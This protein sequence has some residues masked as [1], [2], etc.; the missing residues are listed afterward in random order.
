MPPK[1][2]H[3]AS[4]PSNVD[5]SDEKVKRNNTAD[6]Q[7]SP[8]S[9]AGTEVQDLSLLTTEHL[10]LTCGFSARS[11]FSFCPNHFSSPPVSDDSIGGDIII[12]TDDD[13]ALCSKKICKNN[14]NCLNY[15]GQEKWE[16]DAKVEVLF[17]KNAKLGDNPM[18]QGRIPELP[19]GLKVIFSNLGATCYANASLQVWFRN[20]TFRA[21]VYQCKTS[22]DTSQTYKDSPI[23]H[24][25]V[26][27]AALQEGSLGIYNPS[28]LVESLALR[29]SEQQDAQEFS[30]L[31]MSHLDTEF[32][33]QPD[34]SLR[35]LVIDNF[36]G[37]QIH[38]TICKSCQYQSERAAGF[39]ELEINLSGNITLQEGIKRLLQ[40]E[41]LTGDNRY[42]CSRCRSLQD[43]TRYTQLRKLPPTL[44]FS[45]MRFV[46]DVFTME[47]RK[48]KH[49]ISFPTVLDMSSYVLDTR[50]QEAGVLTNEYELQGVLLHKGPSAYHG[51]YEAQVY[52]KTLQSWFQ[53]N[54]EV[55]TKIKALGDRGTTKKIMNTNDVEYV[56]CLT[57]GRSKLSNPH[58]RRKVESEHENVSNTI[59][60]ILTGGSLV[61]SDNLSSITQADINDSSMI[62]SKDA[63]ML[64]YVLREP[65]GSDFHTESN[66]IPLPHPPASAMDAIQS[67]NHTH[68]QDC[69]AFQQ[70]KDRMLE[71]FYDMRSKI[72]SIY[73][74]WNLT[75]HDQESVVISRQALMTWLTSYCVV[76]ACQNIAVQSF[77]ALEGQESLDSNANNR[78]ATIKNA[79]IQCVHGQLDPDKATE[80]KRIT[81][82]AYQRIVELTNCTFYPLFHPTQVCRLCCEAQFKERLYQH[83]HPRLV[84]EFDRKV[85]GRKANKPGYWISKKWLRDWRLLKPRMHRMSEGDPDPESGEYRQ[86]V[87]CEHDGLSRNPMNRCEIPEEAAAV[88]WTVFPAWDP[89][90]INLE[91]CEICNLLFQTNKEDRKEI[92]RRAEEEKVQLFSLYNTE[93]DEDACDVDTGPCAIIA[94]D[95]VRSWK[96]WLTFPADKPRPGMIDNT[97][98]LCEHDMLVFDPNSPIDLNSSM[99]LISR[100]D[101]DALESYYA[102]GPLISL[103]KMFKEDGSSHFDHQII[104]CEKC[105]LRRKTE[106]TTTKITIRFHDLHN[107][108]N[109]GRKVPGRLTYSGK[110]G[111]ARQSKRLRQIRQHG[112]RRQIEITKIT[113]VKEIKMKIHEEWNIPTICQRLSYHGVELEDNAATAASL[114][115]I[116][117]DFLELNE[118]NEVHESDTEDTANNRDEGKGFCGT[119]L[120]GIVNQTPNYSDPIPC[121]RCTFDNPPHLI[122]CTVCDTPLEKP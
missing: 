100:A 110:T 66:V 94:A 35:S 73:R 58:K 10:L 33:R 22:S 122:A 101:W 112:E 107:L 11:P 12:I 116:A 47:R 4:S 108:A 5:I 68:Q 113:T 19:V 103:T 83:E 8:W 105:R 62:R 3:H 40:S 39:L 63:Y 106:W 87:R 75:S 90:S 118:I 17:T 61:P 15:L 74:S 81:L 59:H 18:Q 78:Q 36:Q 49:V 7:T 38:A 25:Q 30:K 99:V 98:L 34:P 86:H 20:L 45:L 89:P 41:C 109:G 111:G 84:N 51:H 44:H 93:I 119:L 91:P 121:L 72:T 96:D 120:S 53:F 52:D 21:G 79:E 37:E 28:K 70:N 48:S 55:V 54:D 43:A 6:S 23:Y 29:T 104:V 2:R 67:L 77:A 97:S 80:M 82:N 76:L 1:R 65:R 56:Q 92:K 50:H 69:D 13:T 31:F 27:F 26:T 16:N 64:I 88:L 42:H 24:L 60:D 46:Y 32:Q 115:I 102:G 95:F 14:P 57:P 114:Q 9:W 71:Y 85:S 117:D